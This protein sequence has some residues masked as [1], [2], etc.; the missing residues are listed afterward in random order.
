MDLTQFLKAN[1]ASDDDVKALTEGSFA[2]AA[3]RAF[4][5]AFAKAAAAEAAAADAVAARTKAE[6]VVAETTDWYNN[7]A[8]V[9]YGKLQNEVVAAKA[10]EARYIAAL[11]VAQERGLIDVAKDLG[12]EPEKKEPVTAA[13]A[14]D[15]TKYMTR[16]EIL[17]I[18]EKEG[19]AIALVQD[20]AAEHSRLFPDKPLNWRQLRRD[21]MAAKQPVEAYW[22]SKYGV[23]AARE[24]RV[25]DERTAMEARLRKEGADAE[26]Q[27]LVD[28]GFNPALRVPLPS[29][30]VFAP[31]KAPDGSAKQ[32]WEVGENESRQTRLKRAMEN[33]AKSVTH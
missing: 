19:E 10:N 11:K 31:R 29:N 13:A 7:T 23:E 24:K 14:I 1:G 32:P 8:L 27:K 4:D 30:H 16:D 33:E 22:T 12:F 21:A 3:K 5:A 18:A 25:T 26:R 6:A 20:I 28:E 17:A 9:E 15:T 2:G